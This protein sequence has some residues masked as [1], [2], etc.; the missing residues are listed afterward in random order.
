MSVEE[1]VVSRM[2]A[3]LPMLPTRSVPPRFAVPAAAVLV[4]VLAAGVVLL[5]QAARN[6]ALRPPPPI[7]R[8]VLLETFGATSVTFHNALNRNAR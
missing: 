4:D 3:V 5:A 7:A 8:N 2:S 1:N 6:A